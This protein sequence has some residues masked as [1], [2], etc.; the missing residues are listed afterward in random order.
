MF[1]NKYVIREQNENVVLAEI[2]AAKTISRA[3][4]AQI[5]GLNKATVS[6]IV[7]KLMENQLVNETGIG[8]STTSGGRKPI[9]LQFNHQAGLALSI[10]VGYDSLSSVLTYLDGHILEEKIETSRL[11]TKETIVHSIEQLVASYQQ[12]SPETPYGIIGV[13]LAIHG[14][15]HEN[16]ILFTPYYDLDQLPLHQLL[17]ER[18]NLPIYLENEANL[19]AYAEHI[20]STLQ[21]NMVSISI[22]SGI[23]AGVILNEQLYHGHDGRSGEIGHTILIPN[24]RPC[25][26]GNHGC[27][28]QYCSE[29]AILAEFRQE[30][31]QPTATTE[32]F[33]QALKEGNPFAK[34][35]LNETASYLA[36]GINNVIAL[37]SPDLVYLN[38]SLIRKIPTLIPEIQQNSKNVFNQ[39]VPILNSELGAYASLL[40]GAALSIQKFLHVKKLILVP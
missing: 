19:T 16:M 36:I 31:K 30:T 39:H 15:V 33:I 10:D 29:K 38:S 40:G 11:M 34:K 2:I 3:A 9:L 20:F 37:Y 14:I 25:P 24:G 21:P 23:G 5:T 28:E 32:D 35:L 17:Y 18:L 12:I 7:K 26:C 1:I 27:L 13:T 4:L 8:M 6:E 22:H